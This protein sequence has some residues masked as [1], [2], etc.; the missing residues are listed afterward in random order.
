MASGGAWKASIVAERVES[1]GRAPSTLGVGATIA[2]VSAEGHHPV[3]LA[4]TLSMIGD[5]ILLRSGTIPPA[6][7]ATETRKPPLHSCLL[8]TNV[9]HAPLIT[10]A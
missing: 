9:T 8:L 5:V 3:T 7:A 1:G 2:Q 4:A 6:I 10:A